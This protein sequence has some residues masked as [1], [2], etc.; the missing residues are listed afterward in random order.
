M[1]NRSIDVLE[2]WEFDEERYQA[3]VK[4]G[5]NNKVL[6]NVI[7]SYTKEEI[8]ELTGKNENEA[9]ENEI[10]NSIACHVVCDFEELENRYKLDKC[11]YALQFLYDGLLSNDSNMVFIEEDDNVFGDNT[12]EVIADLQQEIKDLKLTD[13]VKFGEDEALVSVY[14]GLLECFIDDRK[15]ETEN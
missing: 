15:E 5:E 11:S 8:L 7:V 12:K 3:R 2:Y 1:E 6:G 9:T 10:K 13:Y 4:I 14:G